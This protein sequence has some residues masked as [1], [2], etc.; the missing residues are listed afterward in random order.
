MVFV[1]GPVPSAGETIVNVVIAL[2]VI[3]LN[4]YVGYRVVG[5]LKGER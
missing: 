2:V 4:L 5:W 1:F 3:G